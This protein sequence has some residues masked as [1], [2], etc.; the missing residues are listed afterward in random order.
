MQH[1]VNE[2][3]ASA[4]NNTKLN[5]SNDYEWLKDAKKKEQSGQY[6]NRSKTADQS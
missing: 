3:C 6:T 1:Q 4:E 2:I 5:S